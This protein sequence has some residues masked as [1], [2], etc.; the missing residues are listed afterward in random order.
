M[1]LV[2]DFSLY[3]DDEILAIS[4]KLADMDITNNTIRNSDEY[5]KKMGNRPIPDVNPA[6]LELKQR[7]QD[8]LTKRK[9]KP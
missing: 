6:F 8:E 7:V 4:K 5:K 1:I 2:K 9:I 3:K